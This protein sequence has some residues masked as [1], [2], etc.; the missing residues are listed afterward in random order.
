MSWVCNLTETANFFYKYYVII[1]N[2]IS[3]SV[4]VLGCAAMQL[5]YV[6]SGKYDL[7]LV[8]DLKPWDLAAGAIL[9]KEAGGLVSNCDGSPYNI[10]DGS[11]AVGGTSE[12][13]QS[14]IA[15]FEAAD[16]A[17]LTVE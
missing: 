17:V 4:R 10:I 15:A 2:L 8:E 7:Y 13:C 1:L 3:I 5:A 12:I 9:V 16:S 11:I 6:A 14:G